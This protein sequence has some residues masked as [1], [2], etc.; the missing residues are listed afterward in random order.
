LVK[1]QLVRV[2]PRSVGDVECSTFVN[3][4]FARLAGVTRLRKHCS[5]IA[6]VEGL[7]ASRDCRAKLSVFGERLASFVVEKVAK[8]SQ[9]RC[10]DRRVANESQMRDVVI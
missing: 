7:A 6:E 3:V 4:E 8:R 1:N 2:F 9:V 5:R 10:Q